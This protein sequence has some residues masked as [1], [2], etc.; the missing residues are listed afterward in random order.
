MRKL[1]RYIIVCVMQSIFVV[2]FVLAGVMFIATLLG[3]LSDIG[4]NGYTLLRAFEY[5]ILSIPSQ[6][7]SLLP[8]AGFVGA[9]M[10]L[11]HIA[12]QN[13]LTVIRAV[14]MSRWQIT[15]ALMK[16]S[17]VIIVVISAI[18]ELY[19]FHWLDR[20][21][22]IKS[23]KLIHQTDNFQKNFWV[24]TKSGMLN[25]GIGRSSNELDNVTF[26]IFKIKLICSQ[27]V[28]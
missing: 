16:A 19:S 28:C 10:G 3:E 22:I 12:L 1:D 21:Q 17:I 20:A 24:K 25:V 18:A 5:S 13:E 8:M 4:S 14:G 26:F 2:L 15:W 11:S 9:L 27:Y 23:P 6:I 7:Y